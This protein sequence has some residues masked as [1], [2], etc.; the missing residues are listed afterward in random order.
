VRDQISIME[1]VGFSGIEF[2]GKTGFRTSQYTVG[3]L[4]RANKTE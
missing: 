2:L 3:V 4:F 1:K